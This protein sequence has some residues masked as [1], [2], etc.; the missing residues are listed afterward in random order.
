MALFARD[1]FDQIRDDHNVVMAIFDQLE[2]KSEA[3]VARRR[4]LVRQLQDELLPHMAAEENV[5]YPRMENG[6]KNHERHLIAEEEHL[7]ERRAFP[8]P[9]HGPAGTDPAARRRRRKHHLPDG[10]L[11]DHQSGDH[12]SADPV[13]G[14]QG[15]VQA[16]ARHGQ[17]HG[18]LMWPRRRRAQRHALLVRYPEGMARGV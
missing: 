6:I 15:A 18:G 8:G 3:A 4:Q 10:A 11:E 1:V 17:A 2:S 7:A 5:F 9:L 16:Q 12:R 13:P 14:L